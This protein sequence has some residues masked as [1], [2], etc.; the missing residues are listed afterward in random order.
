MLV[1][2]RGHLRSAV[3]VLVVWFGVKLYAAIVPKNEDLFLAT[4]KD[5]FVT[6]IN[7]WLTDKA[8]PVH[9]HVTKHSSSTVMLQLYIPSNSFINYSNYK[10]LSTILLAFPKWELLFFTLETMQRRFSR[11]DETYAKF[12]KS[13]GNLKNEC[14]C[15]VHLVSSTHGLC[16]IRMST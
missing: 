1:E 6:E 5:H 8:L 4:L 12:F 9:I 2:I 14:K 13:F 11:Y 10:I 16:C 15:P 7:Q 3:S